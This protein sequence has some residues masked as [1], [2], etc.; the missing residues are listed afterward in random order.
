VTHLPDVVGL[1][2]SD[3]TNVLAD[4][5]LPVLVDHTV[6]GPSAPAGTVVAQDP[7]AGDGVLCQCLITLTVSAS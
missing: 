7:P 5:D 1:S 6:T 4:L 2:I 3:A